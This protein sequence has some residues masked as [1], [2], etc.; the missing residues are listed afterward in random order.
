MALGLREHFIAS[1]DS[2]PHVIVLDVAD[3]ED[4]VPG[5]PAQTRY[6]GDDGGYGFVPFQ[7]Y[8]GLAGRLIPTLL[9]AKRFS[10]A[11]RLCVLQRLVKRLRHAWPDP[12]RLCRGDR[13]VAYPEVRPWID[14][15][16]ALSSGTGLTSNA[17][18][19]ALAQAVVE[20]A[21]RV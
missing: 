15:Q 20:Q 10:G 21:K 17:V 8:E 4:R 14:E 11:P 1:Y 18:L 7:R 6:D 12:W 5:A 16:P 3:T 9:K 2:P 19:K 13:H